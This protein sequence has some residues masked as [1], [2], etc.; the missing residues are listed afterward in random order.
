MGSLQDDAFVLADSDCVITKSL[1]Q[2]FKS[3]V[4]NRCITYVIDY[5]SDYKINGNSRLDM[6]NIFEN[7]HGTK[8]YSIPK[9]H[10]GEFI[11]A[12]ISSINKLMDEFYPA[13]EILMEHYKNGLPHLH[14]EAHVLSYLYYKCGYGGGQA[15]SFI[16]RLWTDSTTFRNVENGDEDLPIWHLPAEKRYGFKRMFDFLSKRN[17]AIEQIPSDLLHTKL[18]MTFQIPNIST[19]RFIYYIAKRI[20]KRILNNI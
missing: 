13:W 4:E 6:K 5:K 1:L 7:L 10:A 12:T 20:G 14:E 8:I 18:K 16:K 3:I 17:F 9:Y 19:N 2:V 15:N 11:G